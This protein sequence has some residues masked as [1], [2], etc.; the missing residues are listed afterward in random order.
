MSQ[1]EKDRRCQP[2]LSRLSEKTALRILLTEYSSLD[3]RLVYRGESSLSI[4]SLEVCPCGLKEFGVFEHLE[5]HVAGA[6]QQATNALPTRGLAGT[7]AVVVV[8][9]QALPDTERRDP[10]FGLVAYRANA[11]L[12]RKKHLIL[13][14]GEVEPPKLTPVN[15]SPL[16][17]GVGPWVCLLVSP[18]LGNDLLAI[19]EVVGTALFLGCRV[20]LGIQVES[21][22][23]KDEEG[24]R[25]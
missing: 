12:L 17:Q 8:H 18:N 3:M 15:S 25:C 4:V 19:A 11:I 5:S 21:S 7:A 1:S 9:R 14:R 6:A 2:R 23:E 24:G 16:G 22:I 13:L 10:R 20:D